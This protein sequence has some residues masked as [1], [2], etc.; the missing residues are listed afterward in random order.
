MLKQMILKHNLP[1]VLLY[2]GR[3]FLADGV[4]KLG[5]RFTD[6]LL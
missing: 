2:M 4:I 6:N 5:Y 3:Q 1:D